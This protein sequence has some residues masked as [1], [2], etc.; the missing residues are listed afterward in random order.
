MGARDCLEPATCKLAKRRKGSRE[1][2]FAAEFEAPELL[3]L[4]IVYEQES[5]FAGGAYN[6]FLKKIDRFS[7]RTLPVS[8]RERE[9]F[10]SRLIAIDQDVK[11]IIEGLKERGMEVT[12]PDLAPFAALMGPARARVGEYSGEENMEIFLGFLE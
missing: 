2:D 4:G 12:A 1:I 5:R 7:S 8:L 9:G 6:P 3:T 10:A 11:Q